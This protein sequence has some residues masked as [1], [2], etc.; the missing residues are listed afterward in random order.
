MILTGRNS[1]ALW[2]SDYVLDV[3]GEFVA[4]EFI[5]VTDFG[6]LLCAVGTERTCTDYGRRLFSN[7]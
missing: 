1:S 4:N 2:S 7:F 3:W 5:T 6:L